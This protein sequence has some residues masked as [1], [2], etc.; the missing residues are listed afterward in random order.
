MGYQVSH[1][2]LSIRKSICTKEATPA[3]NYHH[4]QLAMTLP[5]SAMLPPLWPDLWGRGQQVGAG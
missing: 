3:G 1:S 4:D 2:A 5:L